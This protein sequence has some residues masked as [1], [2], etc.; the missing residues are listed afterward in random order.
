MKAFRDSAE[1]RKG[2]S[3]EVVVA[4]FLKSQGYW[5]VP[6]YDYSGEDGNKAPRMSGVAGF[7]VIPD[8]DVCK[9]GTRF[10]CEVKTKDKATLHKKTGVYEHGISSRHYRD[11]LRVERQS[12]CQ[13][14]LF[15]VEQ[16]TGEILSRKLCE[17]PE[18]RMY[19][20]KKMDRGGMV[21]WPRSEFHTRTWLVG[22][23]L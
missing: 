9:N 6:S 3:G 8:L 11:Y 21:F 23:E 17:L 10:W 14:V 19:D 5:V 22:G 2:R 7:L 20:G 4:E 1:F 16:N 18:P 12:G 15:I 13:V